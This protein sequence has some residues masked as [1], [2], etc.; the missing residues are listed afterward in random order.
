MV[1]LD[2]MTCVPD[3][4]VGSFDYT[5][6]VPDQ[7]IHPQHSY[8]IPCSMSPIAYLVHSI[9]CLAWLHTCLVI[10]NRTSG[11]PDGMIRGTDRLEVARDRLLDGRHAW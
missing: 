6:G 7:M 11:D 5:P 10:A 8:P 1:D 9:A 3:R 4:M 2:H